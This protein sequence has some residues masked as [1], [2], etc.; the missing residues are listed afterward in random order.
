MGHMA[1]N[2]ESQHLSSHFMLTKYVDE[3]MKIN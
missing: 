3:S 1:E 2:V